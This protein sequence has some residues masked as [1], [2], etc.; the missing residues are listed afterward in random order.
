M[1]SKEKVR[2]SQL[3]VGLMAIFA[4]SLIAVLIFLMTGERKLF[5]ESV[6]AYTYLDDAA[7]INPGSPVRLN[8][9]LVGSVRKVELSGEARPNRAIRVTLSID[10]E[11]LSQIPSD[12]EALVASENVLGTKFINIKRGRGKTP[13]EAGGEI[14]ARDVQ[15]FEDLV[16]EGY[17]TLDSLRSILRRVDAIIAEVEV[18][19]G[20]VGKLL[21][22]DALY[23]Q[24][25][26]T[27]AEAHKLT[28][29]LNRTEGTVGKLIND[30]AL[31]D[32]LRAAVSRL[33][34]IIAG[35]EKGEGTAG[36]L[37]KDE[38]LYADVRATVEELRQVMADVNEGK[39]TVGKLLK[40][41]ALHD[42]VAS[43]VERL[44]T[45]LAKVNAGEGTLGQLLVNPQLYESLNGASY[46]LNEFL[47]EFRKNPKKYLRIKASIF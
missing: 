43:V 18:G 23:E 32:E 21:T 30:P 19:R 42:R 31:Y 29:A 5:G 38:A 8:G 2:W 14:A 46:E 25:T 6:I 28:S 10:K 36:K 12:S 33:D 22:D 4:L 9:V 17:A 16:A 11:F 24:L 26:G 37:L 44:D 35:V 39:G 27:V 15:A 13:I 7:G 45:T 3:K 20:S 1:P 40:D 47:K 34:A 41:E